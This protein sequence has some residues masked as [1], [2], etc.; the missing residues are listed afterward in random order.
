MGHALAVAVALDRCA[1]VLVEALQVTQPARH[2]EVENR[3]QLA[4]VVFHWRAGQADALIGPQLANR[5]GGL[6]GAALDV[7]R[8]VQHQHM[9]GLGAQVLEVARHQ[10]IGGQDQVVFVQFGEMLAAPRALQGQHAQI[11][12]EALGFVQPV[13]HQAG[14]HHRQGRC[15]QAP[16]L[17]LQQQMCQG[18]Q[19]LAQPH[20]VAEDAAGAH[21]AQRLQPVQ[22][23]LLVRAQAGLQPGRRFYLQITGIAQA[24]AQVA[25]MLAT[26][27]MQGQAVDVVQA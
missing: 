2:E 27:P 19:G 12:C 6:A 17:F 10:G 7:L 4:Q 1:V 24:T 23:L 5:E 14:R 20:V 22:A 25:H 8:L 18:L 13:G 16:G 3:P 9:P 15:A 11:G 26:L 21:L